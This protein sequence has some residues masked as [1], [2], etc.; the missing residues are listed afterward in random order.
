MEKWDKEKEDQ[1]ERKQEEKGGWKAGKAEED[2]KERAHK[3]N[4]VSFCLFYF[5]FLSK[6]LHLIY[7]FILS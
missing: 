7:S 5:Y 1:E 6:R 2:K 4:F 3:F